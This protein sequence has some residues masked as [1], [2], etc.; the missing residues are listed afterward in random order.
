MC[1]LSIPDLLAI[2]R[3]NIV[4]D[5]PIT[6]EDIKLAKNTFGPYVA[7]LK[8]NIKRSKPLDDI[9]DAITIPRELVV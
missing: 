6:I 3:I 7:T 5:N 9:E 2:L 8:G 4:K 1:T